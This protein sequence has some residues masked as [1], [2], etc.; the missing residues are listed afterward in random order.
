MAE[1]QKTHAGDTAPAPAPARTTGDP[2]RESS[3]DLAA[4]LK[5]TQKT[6]NWRTRS[7]PIQHKRLAGGCHLMVVVPQHWQGR[8]LPPQ[9][10][11]C[12]PIQ[13]ADYRRARCAQAELEAAARAA[14]MMTTPKEN[15]Q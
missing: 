12:E 1:T 5:G 8:S 3:M 13:L 15:C 2:H 11:V 10:P 9:K 4:L 6:G 14:D 7:W